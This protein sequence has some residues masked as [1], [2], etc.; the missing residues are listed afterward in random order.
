MTYSISEKNWV[1]RRKN[2]S[3]Y[4]DQTFISPHHSEKVFSVL[5]LCFNSFHTIKTTIDY[6]LSDP[7]NKFFDYIIVDQST[8]NVVSQQL[9]DYVAQFENIIILTPKENLWSAGGYAFGQEY[10][11]N[12]WYSYLTMLEDDILLASP[13]VFSA[14]QKA[15]R[16][17][18]IWFINACKNTGGEQSRYVQIACYPCWFLE[19]TGIIDPRYFFRGEDIERGARIEKNAIRYSYEKLVL[20]YDYLHPYLKKNNWKI[21]WAYFSLRNQLYTFQKTFSF[22]ILVIAFMYIWYWF[23]KLLFARNLN[24]L[25]IVWLAIKDFLLHRYSLGNSKARIQQTKDLI[26]PIPDDVTPF[27]LKKTEISA[28]TQELFYFSRAPLFSKVDHSWISFSNQNKNFFQ[29]WVLIWWRYNPLYSLFMN[30][31]FIFSI[32]EYQIDWDQVFISFWKN[33]TRFRLIKTLISLF[34]SI[35][36]FVIVWY[37]IILKSLFSRL[38]YYLLHYAF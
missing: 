32:D 38:K 17:D 18:T 26:D 22:G 8:D 6:F 7:E 9:Q 35:V 28:K 15:M 4:L 11:L 25:K 23:S 2:W 14:F 12:N 30:A 20:P 3:D 29:K 27:S 21:W 24:V 34:L 33:S 5:S 16:L 37:L 19:K 10:I 13:G 36:V 1:V 31:P